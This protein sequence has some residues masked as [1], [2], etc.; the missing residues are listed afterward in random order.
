V[1]SRID[2]QVIGGNAGIEPRELVPVSSRIYPEY[3]SRAVTDE[4]VAGGVEREA[5]GYSKI[6]CDRLQILEVPV[7]YDRAVVPARDVELPS[8]RTPAPSGS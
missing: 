2:R 8:A 1:V 4:E 7:P 3:V 6:L 5:A